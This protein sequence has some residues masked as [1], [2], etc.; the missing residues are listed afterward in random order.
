MIVI[1]TQ[2]REN[3]GT[4][5]EPYWKFKGGS[6]YKVTNVPTNALAHEV[7]DAVLSKVDY[8]EYEGP[9]SEQYI[10]DWS[11]EDDGYLSEF[12]QSQLQYDGEITFPEP[13]IE[14]KETV[15]G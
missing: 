13:T 5:T 1:R 10:L 6:D 15:N 8:I 4:E 7:V 12:E 9:M 2:Y 11:V 3:Y 14:Y